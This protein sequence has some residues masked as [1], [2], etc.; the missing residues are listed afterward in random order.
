MALALRRHALGQRRSQPVGH[1]GPR[2]LQRGRHTKRHAQHIADRFEIVGRQ[3][4]DELAVR[5]GHRRRIETL[6]DIA[7]T[8]VGGNRGPHLPDDADVAARSERHLDIVTG[9]KGKSHGHAIAVGLRQRERQ[10]D[11]GDHGGRRRHTVRNRHGRPLL[12]A[13]YQPVMTEARPRPAPRRAVPR[14]APA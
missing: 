14:P 6:H 10:Q 5:V 13:L 2:R 4:L 12:P 3:P 8:H 9:R 7:Q 1:L 11:L